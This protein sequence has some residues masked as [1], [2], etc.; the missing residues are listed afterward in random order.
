MRQGRQPKSSK[1]QEQEGHGL[2]RELNPDIDP[3]GMPSKPFFADKNA[4]ELWDLTVPLLA[5]TGILSAVD[6]PK[7]VAM[8]H[9]WALYLAEMR[10]GKPR[11]ME[12]A[13][14][15]DRFNKLAGYFGMSPVERCG[16]AAEKPAVDPKVVKFFGD[17][18]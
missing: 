1:K 15:F 3:G 10:K 13:R 14:A 11:P 18:G 9:W 7:L 4:D 8:C 2:K 16:L 17:V 6:Q 12:V 5:E